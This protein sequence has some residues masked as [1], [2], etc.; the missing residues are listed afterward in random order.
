M[1]VV[2]PLASEIHGKEYYGKVL[3]EYKNTLT[4]YKDVK[5]YNVITSTKQVKSIP[6]NVDDI[7]IL[8]F[9]TGGTSKLGLEIAKKYN[10]LVVTIAHGEHNS[11]PSA[12]SCKG[13][14]NILGIPCI[15]LYSNR[16]REIIDVFRKVY[17]A[18]S[19]Y[20]H[21]RSLRILLVDEKTKTR[22]A[23]IL[24]NTVRGVLVIPIP[25]E[26]IDKEL[27]LVSEENVNSVVKYLTKT[28][29]I[30]FNHLN[31]VKSIIK[32]YLV[33][34]KLIKE[35]KANALTLNCFNF[36]SRR[37]ITPCLPLAILNSEGIPAACEEDY[38]S[39]LLLAL[40]LK[41][42]GKPGWIGNPS[43]IDGN[44]IVFAHC[45]IA[46]SLAKRVQL[47]PHFETGLPVAISGEVGLERVLLTRLSYDYKEL[48]VYE[49]EIV[50]SGLLSKNRCRTQI[51]LKLS[52]L[53]PQDFIETA[54]G[55]HH[56]IIPSSEVCNELEYI[57][58]LLRLKVVVYK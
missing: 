8:I 51:H 22:D 31:S 12:L 16:P 39:L 44:T 3:D 42:T 47:L 27:N 17:N 26:V 25:P 46:F 5:F 56:V 52:K 50:K 7:P 54:R 29:S 58:K 20:S 1:L 37:G 33:F 32:Y 38:H 35:Y 57:G 14:C 28:F 36:I 18:Y 24:E 15:T 10:R 40:S 21:I 6:C 13:K 11:L 53:K 23:I 41:L 30:S 9:L 4:T 2:Y 34:R 45:T 43:A 19:A 55:N 48:I 49:G